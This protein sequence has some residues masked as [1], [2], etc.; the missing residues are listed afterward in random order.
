MKR[1]TVLGAF[2]C[3]AAA[4]AGCAE[5]ASRTA[6]STAPERST[7]PAFGSE[8]ELSAY[9]VGLARE[10][11]DLRRRESEVSGNVADAMPEQAEAATFEAPAPVAAQ[12]ASARAAEG[13]SV[14]NV[15]HAGVDEGGIV[16]VHGDYLV[17]L[18]RGRLFTVRIGG[19]ALQPVS[20]VDAFGPDIDPSASWYDEL[21]VSGD[22]VV[23]IGFSYERGGTEVGLFRISPDGQ[24]RHR[25]TYHLRS[26][27]YYSSRNYA[28]RLIDGKLIFYTPLYLALNEE[29][30][31][32]GF[33]A[34]RRWH[35]GAERDAFSRI[36][37]ATRVYRAGRP[38]NAESG[39][40][41]HTVTV[42]DLQTE[43]MGCEGTAVLG[44]PGRVFY[45]SPG[46]VYVWV[47]DW[48]RRENEKGAESM[49]YRIPL[50][51]AGP[52]ALAV[53][54]S[55]VD[56]F[57]FLESADRHLNVLVRSGADGDGMWHGET[58]GGSTSLLRV[59]LDSFGD[60]GATAS[61]ERYR[62]LPTPAGYTFQNRFVGDYLLYGT[63]SG[64]GPPEQRAHA[65]LYAVPWAE[66]PAAELPLPHGVDRIESM[67][68]DAVVV[69]SDGQNLHFSAVRLG[70][71]P[72]L[73]QRYVSAGASQGE[74]RSHGFFYKPDGRDGGI[75]GLPIRGE[76][77]P[78]YAH[79]RQGSASILFL[80]NRLSRFE[81]LG[82]LAA[83][84]DG[85]GDDGCR[86]SCV[87]W[88]GNARPLFL[89]GRIF[90]LLGYEIVE[91]RLDGG[92]IQEARRISYA[93]RAV[94]AGRRG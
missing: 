70:A 82:E 12:D 64:W 10:Q 84:A 1:I 52:S 35:P 45:V 4:V 68:G 46:A 40:A 50:D 91:G 19:N 21:L 24:L 83:R 88:Y 67:G 61:A 42:C 94:V 72:Q 27:D 26:N 75:L 25:S 18:R 38:V 43:E 73:A 65:T 49:V 56:Q 33:P 44:P 6:V 37:P 47:S 80:R 7:L 2:A 89:R 31:F 90:A 34:M 30:P 5:S 22:A 93:P 36:L 87:D 74:L 15:Q 66:G 62:P 39:L 29:D 8:G 60:G 48:V 85:S 14:T 59:P 86:A 17:M 41:L 69:G 81:E 13:E 20:A 78:G 55:P 92:T 57:S 53:R 63:G 11:R 71:R 54:G 77:V 23:V 76:G 51:G 3:F 32:A 16:K 9:L 58:T 79:L 28:S